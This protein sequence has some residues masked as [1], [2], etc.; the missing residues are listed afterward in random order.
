MQRLLAIAFACSALCMIAASPAQAAERECRPSLSN[1]WHCPGVGETQQPTKPVERACRPSL[2]NGYH[3]P[4]AAAP[5]SSTSS[6]SANQT[7]PR[8][9]RATQ[10]SEG[11]CR[12]SL[13]NDFH[14]PGQP[15][16]PGHLTG[17]G[18]YT[19]EARAISHCPSGTV[20]WLNEETGVYHYRGSHW[21]GNTKHGAYM[22]E[23]DS[24]SAGMRAAKNE[25]HP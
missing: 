20:V 2:S 19:T 14:C 8:T 10:K 9:K 22:C 16:L 25:H 17:V 21:Y 4:G 3:C 18:E 5:S 1:L 13:S 24:V 12:P 6:N 15:S 23:S 7:M 11:S